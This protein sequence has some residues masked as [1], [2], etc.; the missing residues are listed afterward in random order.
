VPL[1][2]RDR[3]LRVTRSESGEVVFYL[4]EDLAAG[5]QH[6]LYEMEYEVAQL[7]DGTR[8]VDKVAKLINKRRKISLQATDVEK[9]AGQLLALGFVVDEG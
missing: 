5:K 2:F 9:F 8:S 7:L 4:V 3:D 1:R 6:R